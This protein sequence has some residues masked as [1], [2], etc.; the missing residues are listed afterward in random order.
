MKTQSNSNQNQLTNK[1]I[2]PNNLKKCQIH[3]VMGTG[4]VGKTC[5]AAAL[6]ARAA[7]QGLKVLILTIDP[8]KRLAQSLGI[9]PGAGIVRVPD[10]N[11]KGELFA[12]VVEHKSIF[13]KFVAEASGLGP[14]APLFKNKLYLE[15]STGLSGSQEFTS[16][17]LLYEARQSGNYDLIVLDTPPVQHAIDFLRAPQNLSRLIN[18]GVAKWFRQAPKERNLMFR[19]FTHGTGQVFKFVERLTGNEFIMSLAEFFNGIQSW[20]DKLEQRL[21]DAQN[22]LLDSETRFHLVTGHDLGKISEAQRVAESILGESFHLE[23][24]VLNRSR[25]Q[26]IMAKFHTKETM[27]ELVTSNNTSKPEAL[28]VVQ[29]FCKALDKFYLSRESFFE[30]CFVN[31]GKRANLKLLKLEDLGEPIDKLPSI[32]QMSYHKTIQMMLN[33]GLK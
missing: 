21:V 16:L 5:I 29:D 1:N 31:L 9:N 11:F 10:Q 3:I 2:S 4:G 23:S 25:P 20:Q 17:Q 28:V 22:L 14:Q 13:D 32:V 15:L 26:W 33:E 18:E 8:S 24:I 27:N 19:L 12:A 7:G 30:E 6:G